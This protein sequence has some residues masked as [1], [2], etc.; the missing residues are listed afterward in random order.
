MGFQPL[1]APGNLRWLAK[2]GKTVDAITQAWTIGP[3]NHVPG[4]YCPIVVG[5]TSGITKICDH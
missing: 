5:D 4:A 3:S 1:A 2:I